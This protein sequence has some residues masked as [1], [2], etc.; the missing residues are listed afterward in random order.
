MAEPAAA[1]SSF[2]HLELNATDFAK[3]KSFYGELFGWQFQ[4]MDMGPAGTYSTFKPTDGPGGG[5]FSAP[6][7]PEGWLAYMGVEDIHAATDKAK[8]LGATAHVGP[9]EIPGV[10]WMTIL[11]DPNGA[12]FAL[13]QPKA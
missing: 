12:R 6:G 13:F 10:G 8:Q 5:L 3:A 9:H 11:T 1:G 4:D 7:V 2:V